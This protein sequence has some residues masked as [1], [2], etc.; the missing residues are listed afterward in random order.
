[1]AKVRNKTKQMLAQLAGARGKARADHFAEGNTL[2]SWRG[3]APTVTKDRE[4]EQ[5]RR[6]CRGR[7]SYEGR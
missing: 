2:S 6:A 4:K 1:M 5:S 3:A 7:V